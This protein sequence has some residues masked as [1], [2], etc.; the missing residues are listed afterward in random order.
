M[1]SLTTTV[2]LDILR[3]RG[4]EIVEN[5]SDVHISQLYN[6]KEATAMAFINKQ[7]DVIRNAH[8]ELNSL[9]IEW[10]EKYPDY[11]QILSSKVDQSHRDK[12]RISV[13]LNPR[14]VELVVIEISI[15]GMIYI[16]KHGIKFGQWEW[17]WDYGY[18]SKLITD[19][20][21]TLW[22]QEF[23]DFIDR[24]RDIYTN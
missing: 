19:R 21:N 14:N 5:L 22:I 18:N 3:N 12:D 16:R 9:V 13:F 6:I 1:K 15:V 10:N 7:R 8:F 2:F 11:N 24:L 4:S 17:E 20:F 23:A